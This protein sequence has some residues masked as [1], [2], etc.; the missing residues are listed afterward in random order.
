MAGRA[1]APAAGSVKR[2]Y[3]KAEAT[4]EGGIALD[5]KPVRTPGRNPLVAPN[6]AL[7]EAI[8][9]EWNNQSG[10]IDP[11]TMPLTGLTNAAI[12][13]IAPNKD[14]FA[15]GL[16]AYG[17]SDLLC[18]RAEEPPR[19]VERQAAAWD[20]IIAW[21]RR[22]FDIDLVV[23]AG[24]IHKPQPRATLDQLD[25]AVHARSAFDLAGLSPLVTIGGSLIVAL[26]L[27]E[28]AVDLDTGWAAVALADLWQAEH[29]G[30]DA[31]A[32]QVLAAR[33]GDF[34]SGYLFL[35]LL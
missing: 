15:H 13:R 6:A 10:T 8:A 26:A 14:A 19:L 16:A 20:P 4:A 24:V 1:L 7:A 5:G 30:A 28:Q 3:K 34:T 35:S 9:A 29:W 11:R 18:Y 27:A 33:R 21:A 25:Q 17:G 2:F 22:R 32:E 31:E 23:S 12:D